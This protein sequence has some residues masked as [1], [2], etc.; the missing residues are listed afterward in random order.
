[1]TDL[2]SPAWCEQQYEY[3]LS[4][5]GRVRQTPAMR[6]G[7]TVHKELEEQVLGIEVPVQVET[8][9]DRFGLKLWNA[10]RSLRIL[11]DTGLTRELQVWGVSEGEIVNGVIDEISTRCPDEPMEAAII[12]DLKD[13]KNGTK[14]R[15]GKKNEQLPTDQRTLTDF[16]TSSQTGSVL[17]QNTSFLGTLQ[18]EKPKSYYITDVKTRQSRT[19]PAPGSQFRPTQMQ[20]M[21]YHRLLTSLAANEV[22]ADK[23]FERFRLNPY[24]NFSDSF[25]AEIANLDIAPD[26]ATD[27]GNGETQREDPLTELLEHNTLASL[28]ILL[29]AEYAKVLPITSFR[30]PISPLLTAEFRT[31]SPTMVSEVEMANAGMLIGRR[32]F[33]FD[34]AKVDAYI[35]SEMAWWKG[36]RETKGVEIEEAYKCRICEFAEGCTWRATKVEEGLRKAKLRSEAR[37]RSDI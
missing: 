12:E 36:E 6:Q 26:V 10:I 4:K 16:L 31:A 20:L 29:I 21:I 17:D 22:P 14:R 18:E 34:G 35:R 33:P 30:S 27:E 8:R 2:V 15:K 23:L 19:M 11:R 3:S 24:A 1:M 32:S 28:W 37:R 5:Y 25:I 13:E 7:S 9:E